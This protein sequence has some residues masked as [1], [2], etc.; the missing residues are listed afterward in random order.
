MV[1]LNIKYIVKVKKFNVIG[2]LLKSVS[3][4][5]DKV[6]IKVGGGWC[7]SMFLKC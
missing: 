2:I 1:F 6:N 5:N 3:E 4:R 7:L